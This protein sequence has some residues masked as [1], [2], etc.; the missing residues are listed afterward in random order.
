M[1]DGIIHKDI[2]DGIELVPWLNI[3]AIVEGV[4]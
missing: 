2:E 4:E 1:V 3:D